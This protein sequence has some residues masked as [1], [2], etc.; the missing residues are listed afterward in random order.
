M[1][2]KLHN[3]VLDLNTPQIMGILNVTPDSFSDGGSYQSLDKALRQAER[4]IKEGASII[5]IGGESTRPGSSAPTEDEELERVIKACEAVCQNFDAAVSID[6]SRPLVMEECRKAGAHIW[7]DVRALQLEGAVDMALKLKIPVILMHMQGTPKTMQ[8][9]P[10]Y[11]DVADEVFC[12][13]K[14]RSRLLTDKG[15]ESQHILWD[16]G[17]GFGKSLADNYKLLLHLDKFTSQGFACVAALSR[18]SMIG[19][20]T[21]VEIPSERVVGSAVAAALCAERGAHIFRVHDVKATRE[22]LSVVRALREQI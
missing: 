22:A 20:V 21:G 13:L 17:F 6:T 8:D 15:F 7:N 1:Q 18:K 12:F 4:M 19:A 2:L 3:R 9:Q 14:E 16:V 10:C 5:D 11:T